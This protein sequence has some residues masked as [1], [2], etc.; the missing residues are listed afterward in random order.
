MKK[1]VLVLLVIIA[2]A[3]SAWYWWQDYS[4]SSQNGESHLTLHGNV[5]IREV[6]LGF[7]V[8][9][10]VIEVMFDEGAAITAG[11]V[12]ARLDPAPY[13]RAVEQARATLSAAEAEARRLKAGFRR[14]EIAQAK[15]S[16]E[17]AG[18]VL[19]NARLSANRARA[20]ITSNA[21][22][23]EE[24]DDRVA[25]EAEA[26]KQL[27]AAQASFDLLQAGYR[28]ED[29]AKAQAQADQA[30]AA[31]AAAEIQLGDTTLA[32]PSA[33]TL[34][35]RALEPG[36]I[37]QPGATVLTLSLDR[38][39]WVRAFVDEP[40][41]G[42]VV[43]GTE[44]EIFTDSRPNKPY[45]GTIGFVSPRAEFTP[46][47]VET[48]SLRTSLVYRLRIVVSDPDS[49]LRQGMPVTVLLAKKTDS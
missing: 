18:V 28:S 38:P 1:T 33:G 46:K 15:A 23:Q 41:M 25:R 49:F 11:D 36:A 8:S 21:I 35:T 29:I 37:V 22:T 32:A 39:V 13:Q 3:A 20:L 45:R 24:H 14:E 2:L 34:S 40:N 17:Q 26:E 7:R 30:R 6:N 12:L 43:P 31:L 48:Q 10:R 5:D 42:L 4:R 47:N 16:L 27:Q 9:G 44:V 19:A